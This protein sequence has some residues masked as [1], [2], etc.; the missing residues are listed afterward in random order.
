VSADSR[1]V[2]AT[3][4]CAHDLLAL[5]VR[6]GTDVGVRRTAPSLLR[7]P[8]GPRTGYTR[9][10][11]CF[12]TRCSA[13]A[14]HPRRCSSFCVWCERAPVCSRASQPRIPAL[15]SPPIAPRPPAHRP[16]VLMSR[17]LAGGYDG[18]CCYSQCGQRACLVRGT[19][20]QH[21]RM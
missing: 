3:R 12:S 7:T 21:V 9:H 18:G 15:T 5:Y 11:R 17:L 1:A 19:W 2:V 4:P 13:K 16:C 6:E 20:K 14:G 10:R 8:P